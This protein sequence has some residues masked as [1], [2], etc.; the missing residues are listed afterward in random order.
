[1]CALFTACR[2]RD[3]TVSRGWPNPCHIR[4]IMPGQE[5]TGAL[6]SDDHHRKLL[7]VLLYLV[8]LVSRHPGHL[9]CHPLRVLGLLA[10]ARDE[11][12][13]LTGLALL[14]ALA[15]ARDEAWGVRVVGAADHLAM[16]H[17]TLPARDALTRT[18]GLALLAVALGGAVTENVRPAVLVTWQ[19]ELVAQVT[20]LLPEAAVAVL[21]AAEPCT[22]RDAPADSSHGCSAVAEEA[23]ALAGGDQGL[24]LF[25]SGKGT[26]HCS[27]AECNRKRSHRE[28]F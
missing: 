16:E 14:L 28:S 27:A 5:R 21:A 1:M 18:R 6:D 2:P 11:R 20:E 15:G 7:A 25:G 4:F 23:I 19:A 13:K 26:G 8:G 10:P 24:E 17:G 9:A 3:V 22:V 12:C